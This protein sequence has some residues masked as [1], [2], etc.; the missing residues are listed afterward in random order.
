MP[1]DGISLPPKKGGLRHVP[2]GGSK[3]RLHQRRHRAEGGMTA[4]GMARPR[5]ALS[6]WAAAEEALRK[7]Q[8]A[9]DAHI[10]EDA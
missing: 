4:N 6:L 3:V 7:A 8:G 10:S 1:A 5:P 9:C 2:L